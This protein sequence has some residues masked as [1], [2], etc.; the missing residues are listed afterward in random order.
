MQGNENQITDV[1]A[2]NKI[3]RQKSAMWKESGL[4][5]EPASNGKKKEYCMLSIAGKEMISNR[6]HK[7]E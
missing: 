3:G 4:V 2:E 7:V 6:K 1:H 5:M